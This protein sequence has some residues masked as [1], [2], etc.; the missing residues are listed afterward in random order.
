MR[1]DDGINQSINRPQDGVINLYHN[2][3]AW[4]LMS[5]WTRA[6]FFAR[7]SE[8]QTLSS[9]SKLGHMDERFLSDSPGPTFFTKVRKLWWFNKG[10][11][12]STSPINESNDTCHRLPQLFSQGRF[13]EIL[14]SRKR[15]VRYLTSKFLEK[16]K[17]ENPH[18]VCFR[19]N[20]MFSHL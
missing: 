11:I 14:G 9:F 2:S 17:K 6:R 5:V 16:T 3:L 12:K 20:V 7:F 10:S 13:G 8:I 18:N 15:S 19:I 1:N 4:S